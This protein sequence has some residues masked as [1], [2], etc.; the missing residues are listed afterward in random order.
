MA[1]R[2]ADPKALLRDLPEEQFRL[3]F[4]AVA[5]LFLTMKNEAIRRGIWDS[6]KKAR[7]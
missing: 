7:P 5:D 2:D 4:W 1:L 3:A 6:F